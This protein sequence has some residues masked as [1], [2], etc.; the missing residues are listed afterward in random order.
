MTIVLVHGN[1]RGV[2]TTSPLSVTLANTPT[3]GNLL[4][5][6]FQCH[7][8]N[9][10][11]SNHISA[12]TQTGVTWT[13]QK[14]SY[15]GDVRNLDIWAG[16]VGASPGTGISIAVTNSGFITDMAADVCEWS[17]LLTSG[18]LDQVASDSGTSNNPIDTGTTP[19]TTQAA[20]LWI[21]GIVNGGAMT[22]GSPGGSWTQLD[23]AIYA[24]SSTLCYYYQIVTATGTASVSV[25]PS[26]GAT[27]FAGAMTTYFA[28][29]AAAAKAK[30][31]ICQQLQAN[32][33]TTQFKVPKA[34]E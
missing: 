20:E 13:S 11:T 25:V 24:G 18:F 29:T 16:V 30:Q 19:T 15:N 33:C 21:G 3:Q 27:T 28:S 2:G 9:S 6:V 4:I 32:Q 5:L 17:G 1:D 31:F 12:I 34:I 10:G 26:G 8:S 23:N 22:Q 14:T 7:G